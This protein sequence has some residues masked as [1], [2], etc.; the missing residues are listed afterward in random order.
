MNELG[1]VMLVIFVALIVFIILKQKRDQKKL[2]KQQA[3]AEALKQSAH[4]SFEHD[5]EN[6]LKHSA[7]SSEPTNEDS[8]S[9]NNLKDS[10]GLKDSADQAIPTELNTEATSDA[11]FNQNEEMVKSVESLV[12]SNNGKDANKKSNKK[13]VFVL[14]LMNSSKMIAIS[15]LHNML[16]GVGAHYTSKET[17]VLENSDKQPFVT[18]ANLYEPGTFPLEDA[19]NK[20]SSGVV[21]IL[22]LPTC[23]K[24][25]K[26]MD[27]FIML[28]RKI[29]QKINGRMYDEQRKIINES[30]LKN[31]RSAALDFDS[32]SLLKN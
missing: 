29:S 18:I 9:H 23:V 32:V 15:D 21:L 6:H 8:D 10:K 12:E 24:A 14:F 19:E 25:M 13:E 16:R 4:A 26:A 7:T 20:F 2:E 22:E 11:V 30:D 1:I 17:Y 31:M 27:D 3:N 5:L 28:G